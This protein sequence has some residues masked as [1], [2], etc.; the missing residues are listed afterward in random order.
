MNINLNLD[1]EI[2]F[3]HERSYANQ[4]PGGSEHIPASIILTSVK[5][6]GIEIITLL[7]KDELEGMQEEILNKDF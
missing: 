1:V 6:K 2:E 4:T 5:C 7:S 3:D